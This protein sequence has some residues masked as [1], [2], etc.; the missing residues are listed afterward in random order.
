MG[1]K[2]KKGSEWRKWDLHVHTPSSYDYKDKSITNEDI[3]NKLKENNISVVAITDHHI[4]DVKRIKELQILWEKK[5]ITVLP[6]IE[7][8]C[9]L[10]WSTSV[11]FIWIFPENSNILDIWT[12]L[13]WKHNLT[14]SDI[15]RIW[16]DKIYAD[17]KET[18]DT[19][20]EL[21]WIIT[22]H[23]WTKTNSV[24]SLKQKDAVKSDIV[25]VVDIY[26]LWRYKDKE[27]IYEKIVFPNIKKKFPLIICSDNHDIN[28]YILKQN[29]WIKADPTFEWLKQII[30]EPEERVFIWENSPEFE[31]N[32]PYFNSIEIK[33]SIQI[34]SNDETLK[35][36]ENEIILN[37]NLV[38]IIWWRWE[39]KS[40]LINYLWSSLKK[41]D[42]SEF[43]F[44]KNFLIEYHKINTTDISDEDKQKFISSNK[45][46]NDLDFIFIEQWKLKKETGRNL[47]Q[48]L[49]EML[50]IENASFSKDL[51]NDIYNINQEIDKIEN[52]EKQKDEMGN[53]I[54]SITFQDEIINKNKK[55]IENLQNSKTKEQ[56]K[57]YNKNL[58]EI[59]K[60]KN[61]IEQA[62]KII[63]KIDSFV[64]EV[65]NINKD[66]IFEKIDLQEYKNKITEKKKEFETSIKNK[67]ENNDKIKE[68]LLKTWISWDLTSLLE[69]ITNYQNIID[70]AE[71]NK[72]EVEQKDS[73]IKRLKEKRSEL[74]ELIKK[75]YE[76]QKK[77]ID[78]K[79]GNFLD[80]HPEGR[81]ELIK[82]ILLNDDNI[83]ISWKIFF[84]KNKF[85]EL[86]RDAVHHSQ[87]NKDE[88]EENFWIK[89][90]ESL[91]IYIKDNINSK[92]DDTNHKKQ[93]FIN[94]FFNLET[95]AK[96]LRTEAEI[97]YN[98]KELSK[99][100]VWQKWTA[101]LR[102]H[103]A[104]SAFDKPIIFDQPED[105]LDND[106]II[107]ELIDIFK[108]LKKYRQI[109]IVTHNANLVVNADAE[110]VI[111]AENI[112]WVLKYNSWSLENS[113]IKDKVCKILEWGKVAFEQ[114][115]KKYNF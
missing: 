36:E 47:S 27:A 97:T 81:K 75:E 70:E 9:E 25:E 93:D 92:L 79:W 99:L 102:I 76:R 94:L 40:T 52:R 66:N 42:N 73:E 56:I 1:N 17:L 98:W 103:L 16:N 62:D 105:D 23:W 61:T 77:D 112:D 86:L 2:Y 10:W 58:K 108:E 87:Y 53:L 13:S 95:R 57:N 5:N 59:S 41:Y 19:I 78:K 72:R 30:Y 45:D 32:K 15:K 8:R 85:Y 39:W 114:R 26:E 50:K 51:N 46:E 31:N 48:K 104:N 71:K 22:I 43:T 74:W 107:K 3:I 18:A 83:V 68:E 90:L 7:L 55:L 64:E 106:F 63:T 35:L 109:I 14:E 4:I 33:E 69:N 110:Q 34:Y 115:R 88:L 100:S 113:L 96:Y 29:C 38:T 11:H 37:K 12:K 54:N 84:N 65:K 20:K 67:E 60:D 21:G 82:K 44:D 101:Y 111:V 91:S 28:Q 80:N 6:W 89:D 49:K 24:E